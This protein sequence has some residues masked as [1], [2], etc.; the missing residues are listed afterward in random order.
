MATQPRVAQPG[1]SLP[2]RVPCGPSLNSEE[3]AA[4][5]QEIPGAAGILLAL[6]VG[7]GGCGPGSHFPAAP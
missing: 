1:T 2:S 4:G 7:S 3:E 6:T 5:G